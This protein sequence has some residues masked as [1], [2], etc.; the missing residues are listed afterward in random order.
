MSINGLVMYNIFVYV[1]QTLTNDAHSLAYITWST[2]TN[3]IFMVT[4]DQ[5]I[6]SGSF[7]NL[8]VSYDYGKNFTLQNKLLGP[9]QTSVE[10]IYSSPANGAT[11]VLVDVRNKIL[12]LTNND[13]EN[14]TSTTLTWSPDV[15]ALHPVFTDIIAGLDNKTKSLYISKDFGKTWTL[16]SSNVKSFYWGVAGLDTNRTMFVEEMTNSTQASKVWRN[17]DLFI[18]NKK[19]PLM[20]NVMDF[21]V[22]DDYLFVVQNLSSQESLSLFVS[23]ER[24]PFSQAKFPPDADGKKLLEREYYVADSSEEQVFIAVNHA[25]NH[26]N[27]YISEARGLKFSLSLERVLYFN[28]LS[29]VSVA[30]LRQYAP[31]RFLDF[32]RVAALRGV[33]ISTQLEYGLVGQRHLRTVITYDKGGE[34]E[35]IEP[36][37]H[38]TN[39]QPITCKLP[40]CSLHLSMTFGQ[41]NP[42]LLTEPILSSTSAPGLLMAT[43]ML[44]RVVG[45][46]YGVYVS[47]TGGAT[48]DMV[49]DDEHYYNYG[50]HGGIMVA[51]LKYH[52]RSR[53]STNYLLFSCD[54]GLTWKRK[55]FSDSDIKVYGVIT[56][57]GEQ[58]TVFTIF[59]DYPT[60]REWVTVRVDLRK[61]LGNNCTDSDYL[62]WHPSDEHNDSVCLMGRDISFE[63]R[64]RHSRCFNG[65]DYDRSVSNV[66]CRCSREDYECD[67][68]FE[69]RFTDG[70]CYPV[71]GLEV[72]TSVPPSCSQGNSTYTVTR[73]YV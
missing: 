21:E 59:G 31:Y 64:R 8:Y 66:N 55:N 18:S 10:D 44:G 69:H 20:S 43:G 58:T 34:W 63:R 45:F 54:E 72:D 17:D 27:L 9:K 57:P 7:S 70:N 23:H 3:T 53:V 48:W 41:I 40:D 37:A 56:E 36:P 47:N 14:F 29:D 15:L 16:A 11:F 30:W 13:C 33:Y 1:Q 68:D 39:K 49:L 6:R 2:V 24:G 71:M 12:F 73:G 51:V 46:N 38:D 50:D 28:G 67:F 62:I 19:I 5:S 22:F 4:R 35:Y 65:E 26:T 52:V 61:E 60:K 42:Y 25:S 32:Y